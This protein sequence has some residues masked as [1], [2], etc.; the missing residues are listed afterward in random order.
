MYKQITDKLNFLGFELCG[1]G[2]P[3]PDCQE[4]IAMGCFQ[5]HKQTKINSKLKNPIYVKGFRRNCLRMECPT[6]NDREIDN[7][8]L[9]KVAKSR[10]KKINKRFRQYQF[11]NPQM[12]K[13]W[14]VKHF[15]VSPQRQEGYAN[16]DYK[17]MRKRAYEL[18]KSIDIR[19]GV[20]IFH[21]FRRKEQGKRYSLDNIR[22]SPHFHVIGYGNVRGLDTKQVYYESGWLIKN[23]GK[24]NI[25][26]TA[27][28]L[29]S[30]CG[31][32][33]N[34]RKKSIMWFGD[35]SYN[36]L[37]VNKKYV[38]YEYIGLDGKKTFKYIQVKQEEVKD[39]SL[40]PLCH[41]PLMICTNALAKFL[42]YE[43]E[44]GEFYLER[45]TE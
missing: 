17:E 16:E 12:K 43:L 34:K 7:G 11:K 37:T 4:F 8:K 28:Y 2:V 18:M 24:R 39:G 27:Y 32:D 38:Y 15:L 26:H 45:F 42:P 36:K 14:S 23:F 6:C 25:K 33:K 5:E 13:H 31:V 30:H 35:L 19:G 41:S 29:L 44:E 21:P 40:C 9:M 20:M 22:V 3:E 10:A 1:T